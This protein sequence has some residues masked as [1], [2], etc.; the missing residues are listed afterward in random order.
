MHNKIAL[1]QW[2]SLTAGSDTYIIRVNMSEI[3]LYAFEQHMHIVA[4][5]TF[6]SI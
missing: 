6:K 5:Q 2:V 3:I 1:V 4:T